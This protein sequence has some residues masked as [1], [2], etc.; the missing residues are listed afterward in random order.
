MSSISLQEEWI[1]LVMDGEDGPRLD[2]VA[3]EMDRRSDPSYSIV[4]PSSDPSLS[5]GKAIADGVSKAMGLWGLV[6]WLKRRF[7]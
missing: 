2:E 3:A 4:A 7:K 6:D 1:D 5:F